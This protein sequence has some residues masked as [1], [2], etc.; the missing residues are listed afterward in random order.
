MSY[1]ESD[2]QWDAMWDA[3]SEALYP[4][5][6]ERAVAEFTTDRLQSFFMAHRDVAGAPF[7]ALTKAR[8][9]LPTPPVAALVFAAIAVEVGLRAAVLR[10]ITHGL[11]HSE[12]LA[13][14]VTEL[15]MDNRPSLAALRTLSVRI[16]AEHGGVDLD[17]D[18]RPGGT[19]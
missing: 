6:F 15:F 5:H 12:D 13:D 16:L 10:P 18:R 14:A 1:D 4:E 11:V 9:L 8:A 19:E 17:K 2:A 3:A 7:G